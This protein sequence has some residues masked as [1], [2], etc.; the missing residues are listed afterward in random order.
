MPRPGHLPEM[1]DLAPP[2]RPA[3]RWTPRRV[4]ATPAAYDHAHGR[5]IMALVEARGIEVERLRANRLTGV[6]GETD[7]ETYAVRRPPRRS[8]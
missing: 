1:T 3:R 5:R 7:R 6:R 2:V 8:W 4:V